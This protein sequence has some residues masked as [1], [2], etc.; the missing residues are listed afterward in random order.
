MPDGL[1]L[2]LPHVRVKAARR[3]LEEKEEALAAGDR[4]SDENKLS[5]TQYE[6]S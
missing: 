1:N 4:L 5:E 2:S 6:I 3:L